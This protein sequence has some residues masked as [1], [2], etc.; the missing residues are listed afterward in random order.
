MKCDK[1]AITPFTL[2]LAYSVEEAAQLVGVSRQYM[3]QLLRRGAIPVTKIGSRQTRVLTTDLVDF[4]KKC[5]QSTARE[6]AA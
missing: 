4:L 3:R 1:T 2:R 6:V 5:R